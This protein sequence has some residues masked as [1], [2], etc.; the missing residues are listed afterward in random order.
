MRSYGRLP[1]AAVVTTFVKRDPAGLWQLG[2]TYSVSNGTPTAEERV[3]R[4]RL[5]HA[6]EWWGPVI[7]V[8]PHLLGVLAAGYL[9]FRYG[10]QYGLPAAAAASVVGY[11]RM[12]RTSIIFET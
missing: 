6:A 2:G 9:H 1:A 7:S 8:R 12:K 4:Y 10:W 11:S 5:G 3:G